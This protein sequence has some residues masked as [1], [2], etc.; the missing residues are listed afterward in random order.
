[1]L[2]ELRTALN[3]LLYTWRQVQQAKRYRDAC[4]PPEFEEAVSIALIQILEERE[5]DGR[6]YA[7]WLCGEGQSC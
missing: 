7:Y 6:L 4:M 2:R 5:D 1:M 3:I